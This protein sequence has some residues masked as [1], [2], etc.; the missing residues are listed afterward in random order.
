VPPPP[1]QVIQPPAVLP[2]SP[3]VQ[4]PV[5]PPSGGVSQ[6]PAA[7]RR[8]EKVHKHAESNAYGLRTPGESSSDA[9]VP[10]LGGATLLT[11]CLLGLAA[12]T[13]RPGRRPAPATLWVE[14]R[15]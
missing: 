11:I 13:M 14:R 5:P 4:Q 3:P 1:A 2:P 8:K 10:L 12:G 7:A 9:V 6:S 15:R